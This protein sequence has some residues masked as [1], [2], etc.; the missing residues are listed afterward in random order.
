MTT[1]TQWPL[2]LVPLYDSFRVQEGAPK[3]RFVPQVGPSI[4][5]ST[6]LNYSTEQSWT[7]I[8]RGDRYQDL[9]TFYKDTQQG[10]ITILGTD[11]LTK[12]SKQMRIKKLESITRL[13]EDI[14][15]ISLSVEVL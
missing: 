9:L 7:V 14:W 4:D 11:P 13:I 1:P 10:A 6:T 8:L 15:R 5:R 3:R 12:M 2:W